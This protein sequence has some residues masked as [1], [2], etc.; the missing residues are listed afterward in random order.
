MNGS[1]SKWWCPLD[2]IEAHTELRQVC[3]QSTG[4]VGRLAEVTEKFEHDYEREESRIL[5][6]KLRDS[7]GD[8]FIRLGKMAA[9]L[10]AI[11]DG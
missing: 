9:L 3:F 11:R 2:D 4:F 1:S 7:L 8:E 10:E 5:A 6:G